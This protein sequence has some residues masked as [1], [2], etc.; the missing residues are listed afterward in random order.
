M[1]IRKRDFA[2][3]ETGPLA[4]VR[5]IDLSRLICGNTLTQLLGDHGADVIKVE[6]P[7]GDT[8]RSWRKK[9][10]EAHWKTLSRNKRSISL[11]F[12]SDDANAI[13]VRLIASANV[14]VESFRPGT[15]E[16]MGLAPDVLLARNPRLVIVRISGWGQTGPYAL[17][18]GFG[19][20]V[21]GMSG[22]AA[23]SGYPDRGPLLPPNAMADAIAGYAGAMAAMI[24]LRSVEVSGGGGQIIDLPLFDPLFS[25]LGPEAAHYAITGQVKQRSGSRSSNAAP[26]NVYQTSDGKW[27]ALSASIQQMAMRLFQAIDRPELCDDPRFSTNHARVANVDALDEIV[28]AFIATKTQE[29]NLH[30][31][32]AREITIGPIYDISQ[33]MR[34][35]HMQ[36]RETIV[37]LPDR[38]MGAFPMSGI[39]PR[40]T[41]TPGNFY[42][43]APELGEH[44]RQVLGEIGYGEPEIA[45]FVRSGAVIEKQ[46]GGQEQ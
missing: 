28:G 20:L 40:M 11:N 18:P 44:T 4:D 23:M 21:E 29:E 34:D 32:E 7:Q 25:I 26:R 12:R 43:P 6:P 13:L 33:I 1:T 41:G 5:I 24:A 17:R 35:P 2:P 46:F 19:T 45:H 39:V 27:V 22:F 36:Y 37:E 14:L 15:L 16:N 3:N 31:F 30:Y 38:Q 10:I 42:R 9:G 8:L